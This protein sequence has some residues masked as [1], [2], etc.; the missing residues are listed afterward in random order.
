MGGMLFF[1][2]GAVVSARTTRKRNRTTERD[3][4]V[5]S[6]NSTHKLNKFVGTRF[7]AV[8]GWTDADDTSCRMLHSVARV[9]DP[10]N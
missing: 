1:V 4:R 2:S 5:L 3:S 6:P 10:M 7:L 8:D 9:G